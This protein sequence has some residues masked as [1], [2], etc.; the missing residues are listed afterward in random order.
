MLGTILKVNGKLPLS[1]GDAGIN[2]ELFGLKT[3][4]GGIRNR[5]IQVSLTLL[6]NQRL[7]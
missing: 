2:N 4:W 3:R 7:Q 5:G 1:R 6:R